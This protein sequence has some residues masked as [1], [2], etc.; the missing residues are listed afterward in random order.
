[1]AG[2]G[3]VWFKLPNEY[4]TVRL[5][6]DVC[7]QAWSRQKMVTDGFYTNSVGNSSK[8][9]RQHPPCRTK[10]NTLGGSTATIHPVCQVITHH[11]ERAR[12]C[13]CLC[14]RVSEISLIAN[15]RQSCTHQLISIISNI[16]I[17]I[18][19]YIYVYNKACRLMIVI[20]LIDE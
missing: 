14:E 7:K 15:E 20:I 19:I 9:T 13:R 12:A 16:Y 1:M 10:K 6:K 17:Y 2:D 4:I 18:Y 5:T 3:T 8:G 11:R